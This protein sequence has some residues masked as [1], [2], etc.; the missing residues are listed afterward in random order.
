MWASEAYYSESVLPY[1]HVYEN[2]FTNLYFG[3]TVGRVGFDFICMVIIG[4]S[5]RILGYFLMITFNRD[6]QR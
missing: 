1:D 4:L 5:W 3:F 6:K 2:E